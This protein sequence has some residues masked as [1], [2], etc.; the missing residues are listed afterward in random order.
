MAKNTVK[1][2]KYLDVVEEYVAVAA[3]TPGHFVELTSAGKVQVHATAGGNIVPMVALENELE[4]Q[5]ISDA[6]AADDPVQVWIP[7]RGEQVYALLK[8]GENVAIGAFLESAGDGTLQAHTPDVNVSDESDNILG[9]QIVAVALE[10]V[11]MSG[12]SG[13]DPSGRIEVMIV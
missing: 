7:Q 9:N 4:G 12:S 6:Y 11:Y 13:A 1:I 10:A 8:D 3:I 2:K 5:T